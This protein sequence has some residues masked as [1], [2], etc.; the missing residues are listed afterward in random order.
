MEKG[1]EPTI[2]HF[3]GFLDAMAEKYENAH[4]E[5]MKRIGIKNLVRDEWCYRET[6]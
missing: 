1:K 6:V 4:K 3:H 5:C 2:G